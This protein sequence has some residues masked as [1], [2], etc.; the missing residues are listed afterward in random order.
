MSRITRIT[1]I[2]LS[3]AAAGS[4]FAESPDVLTPPPAISTLSRAAVHAEVLQARAAGT[5]RATEADF[6]RNDSLAATRSRAEVHAETLAAIAS[7]EVRAMSHEA[8]TFG[9]PFVAT[10]RTSADAQMAR[11]SR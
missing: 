9:A 6:N 1:A 5:L 10:Q 4:A 2:A 7:G 3:F 8:N 11:A